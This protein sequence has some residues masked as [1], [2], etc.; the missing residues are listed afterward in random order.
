M[1]NSHKFSTAFHTDSH[2]I[3]YIRLV[4]SFYYSNNNI[5]IDLNICISL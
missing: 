3:S 4:V 1:N 2:V 5:F